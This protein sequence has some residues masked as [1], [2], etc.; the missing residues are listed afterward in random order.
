MHVKSLATKTNIKK[1][2]KALENLSQNID[3]MYTETLSRIQKQ[4][5][6]LAQLAMRMLYWIFYSL[7]PLNIEELRHAMA[8]MDLDDDQNSLE[9]EDFHDETLLVTSC[10][11][12]VF[13]DPES[14]IVR[15]VHYTTQEFFNQKGMVIFPNA[16]SE[17]IR[18]CLRYTCMVPFKNLDYSDSW[19]QMG[20]NDQFFAMLRL[21]GCIKLR[22]IENKR[23]RVDMI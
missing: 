9:E 17:I 23:R 18:T 6:D 4:S 7:L 11:G 22:E 20:K 21:L 8:I 14:K 1:V 16:R 13:V 19:D 5:K 10:G 3:E 12:L 15:L 2:R